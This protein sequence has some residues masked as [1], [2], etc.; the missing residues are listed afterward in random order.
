VNAKG[1]YGKTA[2]DIARE[3][4]NGQVADLLKKST[5]TLNPRSKTS[6]NAH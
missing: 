4:R 2:L 1:K 3:H 5:K 6:P